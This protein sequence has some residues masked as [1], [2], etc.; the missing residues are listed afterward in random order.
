LWAVYTGVILCQGDAGDSKPEDAPAQYQIL[1]FIPLTGQ[2]PSVKNLSVCRLKL[3]K[4]LLSIG[5]L[6]KDDEKSIN[7]VG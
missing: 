7:S 6:R 3:T 2:V 1:S 5:K 4:P